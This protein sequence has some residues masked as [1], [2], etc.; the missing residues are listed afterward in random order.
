MKTKT[1]YRKNK[2]YK[3]TL[4]IKHKRLFVTLNIKKGFWYSFE[5]RVNRYLEDIDITQELIDGII[6][7]LIFH[8][9]YE[10]DEKL[11]IKDQ[12]ALLE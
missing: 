7:D 5:K 10:N 4:T 3:I 9:E 11:A 2:K 6:N 8:Y 1:L 12:L